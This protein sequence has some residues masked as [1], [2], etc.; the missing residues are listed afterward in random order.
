MGG[1]ALPVMDAASGQRDAH[2]VNRR[3]PRKVFCMRVSRFLPWHLKIDAMAC[4]HIQ[5]V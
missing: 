3:P 2:H 1:E 4:S 5:A